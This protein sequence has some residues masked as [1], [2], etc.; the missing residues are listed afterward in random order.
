MAGAKYKYLM[1]N[2]DATA[3][4]LVAQNKARLKG[5]KTNH[6]TADE[7]AVHLCGTVALHAQK[8]KYASMFALQKPMKAI[9]PSCLGTPIPMAEIDMPEMF[10]EHIASG[11]AEMA[12]LTGLMSTAAAGGSIPAGL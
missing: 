2:K 3:G 11:A 1:A 5:N 7:T 8:V 12:A 9:I 4:V 6:I 10:L